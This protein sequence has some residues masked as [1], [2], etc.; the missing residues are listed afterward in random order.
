[1]SSPINSQ[2]ALEQLVDRRDY[3]EAIEFD[4]KYLPIIAGS[5]SLLLSFVISS[6]II[7][8]GRKK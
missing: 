2:D 6:R 3:T 8:K 1:M 7:K 4:Q 5:V